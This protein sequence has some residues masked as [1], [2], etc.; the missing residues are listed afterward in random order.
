MLEGGLIRELWSY[1][2]ID[3]KIRYVEKKISKNV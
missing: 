3:C 2:L 1:A